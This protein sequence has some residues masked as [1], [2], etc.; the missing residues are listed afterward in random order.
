[1]AESDTTE[2]GVAKVL[3]K[4]ISEFPK[5]RQFDVYLAGPE[6]CISPA[7]SQLLAAGFSKSQLTAMVV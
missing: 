6:A 2:T 7:M 3:D 4:L 5:V 1:M